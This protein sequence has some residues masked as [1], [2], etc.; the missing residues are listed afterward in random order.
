VG[1]TVL[2]RD[3]HA[4]EATGDEIFDVLP[5]ILLAL[6]PARSAPGE[7]SIGQVASTLPQHLLL[8]GQ[9]EIHAPSLRERLDAR[10]LQPI[11]IAA[12]RAPALPAQRFSLRVA[13]EGAVEAPPTF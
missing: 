9:L 10:K 7:R 1:A 11:V 3:R 13:S 4:H 5:G 2:A 6:V 8:G 12:V